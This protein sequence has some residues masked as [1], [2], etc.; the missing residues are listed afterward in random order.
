MSFIFDALKKL[1]QEKG[2]IP[3][4]NYLKDR[5]LSQIS[6]GQELLKGDFFKNLPK[7]LSLGNLN[8]E[9]LN[10]KWVALTGKEAPPLRTVAIVGGAI[11]MVLLFFSGVLEQK[12]NVK[13]IVPQ[14]SVF[15]GGAAP[16]QAAQGTPGI[17]GWEKGT[18][19][20]FAPKEGGMEENLNP[21]RALPHPKTLVNRMGDPFQQPPLVDDKGNPVVINEASLLPKWDEEPLEEEPT[22]EEPKEEVAVA[23]V[24]QSESGKKEEEMTTEKPKE[25][26]KPVLEGPTAEE[27]AA[28]QTDLEEI[29]GT[30]EAEKK[31]ASLPEEPEYDVSKIKS[32]KR[33]KVKRS[34]ETKGEE[35]AEPAAGEE[36]ASEETGETQTASLGP[37]EVPSEEVRPEESQAPMPVVDVRAELDKRKKQ[38]LIEGIIYNDNPSQSFALIRN[39][40]NNS[41]IIVHEGDDFLEMK[42]SRI[43]LQDIQFVY[44]DQTLV[45][46]VD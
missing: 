34:L 43:N 18:P 38:I 4:P 2:R 45:V 11:L 22:P 27:E 9:S 17:E 46:K 44:F 41:S 26:E 40:L 15:P 8:K 24:D 23:A 37:E 42:V 39:L 14:A 25:D 33:S 32:A 3:S 30:E 6:Q 13:V 29:V 12:K 19:P 5:F 31:V 28:A 16:G 7:D 36:A 1:E 20:A 10:E 35:P 21:F